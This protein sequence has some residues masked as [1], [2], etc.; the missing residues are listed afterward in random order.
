MGEIIK[1]DEEQTPIK[2]S[3]DSVPVV[4]Q[5]NVEISDFEEALQQCFAYRAS[6]FYNIML[7]LFFKV[8]QRD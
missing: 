1:H 2:V 4:R 8:D 5:S 3:L 6:L 7:S